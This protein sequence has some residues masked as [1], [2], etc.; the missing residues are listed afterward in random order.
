M[1][2]YLK[3]LDMMHNLATITTRFSENISYVPKRLLV[4]LLPEEVAVVLSLLLMV[5]AEEEE[6]EEEE[7]EKNGWMVSLF[8]KKMPNIFV[9]YPSTTMVQKS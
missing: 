6:E 7:E 4:D 2:K 9:S 5:T 1:S 3:Y 8:V